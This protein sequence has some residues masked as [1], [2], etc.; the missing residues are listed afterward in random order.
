MNIPLSKKATMPE[1]T[2]KKR[3][4]NLLKKEGSAK[5]ETHK[6]NHLYETP[7]SDIVTNE[8]VRGYN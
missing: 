7:F 4:V 2:P 3:T 6:V 8:Y 5:A 1:A